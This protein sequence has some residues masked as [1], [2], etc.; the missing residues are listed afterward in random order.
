[1][2]DYPITEIVGISRDQA[3]LLAESGIQSSGDLLAYCYNRRTR[4]STASLT[5]LDPA[6]LRRWTNMADLLR[7]GGLTPPAAELL[8]AAGV[9]SVLELRNWDADHLVAKIQRI[10]AARG[11]ADRP[12]SET[13][14]SEWVAVARQ[15][16]LIVQ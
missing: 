6:L 13:L 9:T 11:S 7:V 10:L 3:R 5:G 14:A 8:E 15:L 16:T 2:T 1:M 4:E 12:P